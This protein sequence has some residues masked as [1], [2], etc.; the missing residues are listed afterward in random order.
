M[1]KFVHYDGKMFN[2]GMAAVA[3][4]NYIYSLCHRGL[5]LPQF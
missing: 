4:S 5:F 2:R 3:D 1:D